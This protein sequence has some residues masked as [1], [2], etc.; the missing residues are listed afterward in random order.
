MKIQNK[1]HAKLQKFMQIAS[2]ILSLH[3]VNF[4]LKV[5]VF[6]ENKSIQTSIAQLKFNGNTIGMVPTMGAL[7]YG[8]MS[9]VNKA[10]EENDWVIVSIFVNPTQFNNPEDLKKYPRTLERDLELLKT[11]SKNILVYTPTVKDI[12][13][14]KTKAQHFDFDGLE[15]EMEGMFREGHFDGVGQ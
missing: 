15:L 5:K 9:L 11:Q 2:K 3:A 8:H 10:L 7:H 13:Q 14:D 6:T 12:Y 1:K 4:L